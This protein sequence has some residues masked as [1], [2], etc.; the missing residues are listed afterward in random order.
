MEGVVGYSVFGLSY[1]ELR[2]R[3]YEGRPLMVGSDIEASLR[4][5]GHQLDAP[6]ALGALVHHMPRRVQEHHRLELNHRVDIISTLTAE[7]TPRALSEAAMEHRSARLTGDAIELALDAATEQSKP[8]A[9]AGLLGSDLMGALQ[10]ARREEETRQHAE[11]LVAAGAELIIVKSSASL[12]ELLFGIQAVTRLNLPCWAVVNDELADE[13]DVKSLA[14]R[15]YEMGVEA[16]LFETASVDSG[17]RLL[18]AVEH[19]DGPLVKGALLNAAEGCLRGFPEPLA[20]QWVD[21][22]LALTESGARIIGGGAG[23][24][25]AHTCALAAS[26]GDLH[27]TLSP[28]PVCPF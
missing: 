3:L 25:S 12:L 8:A 13:L 20:D 15:C 21:R 9:V 11:R 6:G 28:P 23:T 27:P 7:T 10:R 4:S 19:Y 16:L 5:L 1:T 14:Q 24:T 2:H 22:A 18:R 17:V 26:L